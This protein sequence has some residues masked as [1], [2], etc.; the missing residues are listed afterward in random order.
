M[1]LFGNKPGTRKSD[2]LVPEGTSSMSFVPPRLSNGPTS[3]D[4][5]PTPPRVLTAPIVV[6]I[7]QAIE[8]LRLLPMDKEPV[9]VVNVLKQT[10]EYFHIRV[11][12]IVADAVRRQRDLDAGVAHLAAEMSSL[13]AEVERRHE[14]IRR[15]AGHREEAVRL[16]RF[17]EGDFEESED[18]EDEVTREV[19]TS[20]YLGAK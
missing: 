20:Q 3:M 18:L 13:K 5:T 7:D 8:L 17:L 15:L 10:L 9:L 16:K 14:E 12:D 4:P 11:A 6:G 1:A 19:T 2:P